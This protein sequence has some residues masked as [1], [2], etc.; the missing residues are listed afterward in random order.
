MNILLT[1]GPFN[2]S[3]MAGEWRR[4]G[5]SH[6]HLTFMVK[7][8]QAV[9][10]KRDGESN[11]EDVDQDLNGDQR[12]RV[13]GVG[14]GERDDDEVHEDVNGDTIER[15]RNDGSARHEREPTAGKVKDGSGAESDEKVKA[16]AESG[17]ACA[18]VKGG[19]AEKSG[20]DALEDARR[21]NL[22]PRQHEGA[23]DIERSSDQAGNE[24]D[25]G[26]SCGGFHS[27][28]L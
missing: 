9:D 22:A 4:C 16:K 17:N 20:G 28:V 13:A 23:S 25:A 12:K 24:N 19:S 26:R 14:A 6:A 7:W 5:I 15:S 11:A 8:R 10:G 18:S 2:P 1:F 27:C 21:S 3:D